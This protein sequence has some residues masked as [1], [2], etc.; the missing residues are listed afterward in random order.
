MPKSFLQSI[1]G[2]MPNIHRTALIGQYKLQLLFNTVF[3]PGDKLLA[4]GL[5]FLYT[6]LNTFQSAMREHKNA[7]DFLTYR[8]TWGIS[9]LVYMYTTNLP[10][11][12]LLT[13][14]RKFCKQT[15]MRKTAPRRNKIKF[16]SIQ[17]RFDD[18]ASNEIRVAELCEKLVKI[19]M[20]ITISRQKSNNTHYL[21]KTETPRNT[22]KNVNPENNDN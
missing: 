17:W 15:Q 16:I 19:S 3:D 22:L 7:V 1:T 18:E 4:S 11:Q 14:G 20:K 21:N 12:P 6:D 2:C 8:N 9:Y 5:V 13:R 10:S